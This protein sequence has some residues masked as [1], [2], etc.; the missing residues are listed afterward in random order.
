[1]GWAALADYRASTVAMG[2]MSAHWPEIL[3]PFQ[4]FGKL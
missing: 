1:M 2:R 4:K 3:F